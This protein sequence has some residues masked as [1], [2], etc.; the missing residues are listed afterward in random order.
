[1]IIIFEL[2]LSIKLYFSRALRLKLYS[3]SFNYQIITP[4][5]CWLPEYCQL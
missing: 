3:S 2:K 1:M 5:L 4:A